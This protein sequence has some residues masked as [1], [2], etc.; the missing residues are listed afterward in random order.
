MGINLAGIFDVL[1]TQEMLLGLF[2]T[3]AGLVF[4]L[5]GFRVSNA[6]VAISFGVLGFVLCASLPLPED[7]RLAACF[8]GALGLGAASTFFVRLSVALLTGFW[9]SYAMLLAIGAWE[10]PQSAVLIIVGV[11]FLC[12][13]SMI[14]VAYRETIAFILSL[15]GTALL[16][17]GMVIF[18]SQTYSL[19][20]HLRHLLVGNPVFAPFV[21]MA[22]T[23]TGFYWQL[24]ELRQRDAG[25]AS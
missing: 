3:G 23:I 18:A 25:V 5:F 12:G 9:A 21:L 1:A 22:G 14:L 24:S 13:A 4:M 11:S 15:E 20:G 8:V 7:A 10:I 17:G 16:I 2:L 6:L 19:A